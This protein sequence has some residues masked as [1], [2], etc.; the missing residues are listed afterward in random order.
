MPTVTSFAISQTMAQPPPTVT[1]DDAAP[2]PH[3]EGARFAL[4]LGRA[5]HIYGAPATRL[6]SVVTKVGAELGFGVNVFS[7]P[8][9]LFVS[10]DVPGEDGFAHLF[11]MHRSEQDFDKLARLDAIW[12]DVVLHRRSA[13][14]A[15]AEI[16]RIDE[17]PPRYGRVATTLALSVTSAV[18]VVFYGGGLDDMGIAA[19][20]GLALS[21]CL[22]VAA[23]RERL[24][25]LV[26]L[27]G[28]GLVS[29]LA[30]VG[31]HFAG[32]GNPDIITLA[33]IITLLPGFMLTT[34]I[35]ELAQRNV[36]S[37]TARL[38]YSA[39]I[40][41][42]LGFGVLAGRKVGVMLVGDV[43][44][45]DAVGMP[46]TWLG[47]LAVAVAGVMIGVLFQAQKRDLLPITLAVLLPYI[48]MRSGI[49]RLGPELGVFIGA[50]IA[51]VVSNLYARV[52]DRPATITR[53][54]GILV[55]VP[56]SLGLLS[57]TQL[58]GGDA[59]GGVEQLVHTLSTAFS[60]VVGLLFSNA[61]ISPRKAL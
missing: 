53:L 48:A 12:N 46:P 18:G 21:L 22:M 32:V 52:F 8:T 5:L 25:G 15:S 36:V 56:G 3:S 13:G 2:D 55:L 19:L 43:A 31:V 57:I 50:L 61:I 34:S 9:A 17:E 14:D 35:A 33:G 29:T 60:L 23:G 20:C 37:G 51:G 27:V 24:I 16:Y 6:E 4:L 47:P 58:V 30:V 11:R 44:S 10:F 7:L 1:P 59:V 26:E 28:A 40:A 54:P 49:D 39:L 38:A 45:A 42:M 41:L